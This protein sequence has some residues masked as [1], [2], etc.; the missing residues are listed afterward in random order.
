MSHPQQGVAGKPRR[1][2]NVKDYRQMFVNITIGI[3]PNQEEMVPCPNME[4]RPI[5][6]AQ[7]RQAYSWTTSS[8][9]VEIDRECQILDQP[10]ESQEAAT[11]QG[12]IAPMQLPKEGGRIQPLEKTPTRSGKEALQRQ[13]LEELLKGKSLNSK[14][15]SIPSD[16]L[17]E[18]LETTRLLPTPWSKREPVP[19]E[20]I[21][22]T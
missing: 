19:V 7:T 10:R 6:L 14:D 20:E 9:S 8:W 22:P 12:T 2:G 3:S 11:D 21:L 13:V 17:A 4:V 15:E 18:R 5:V 1:A 16:A